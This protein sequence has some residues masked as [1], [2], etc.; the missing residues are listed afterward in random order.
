VFSET[1]TPAW[2]PNI[3]TFNGNRRFFAEVQWPELEGN[4]SP[5]ASAE[6]ENEWS[7]TSA[8]PLCIDVVDG[9]NSFTVC[10]NLENWSA[11]ELLLL[12]L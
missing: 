11:K 4:H 9:R 12:H 5:P 7:F 3:L 6:V 2:T 8:L 10:R 1:S